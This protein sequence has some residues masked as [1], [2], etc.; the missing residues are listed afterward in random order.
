[1]VENFFSKYFLD[2]RDISILNWMEIQKNQA[3]S[4]LT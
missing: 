2:Y 3:F 4:F 1:M